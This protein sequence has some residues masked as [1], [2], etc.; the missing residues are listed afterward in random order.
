MYNLYSTP[1]TLEVQNWR[2]IT[3]GDTRTKKLNI[4]DLENMETLNVYTVYI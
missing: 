3:F 1:T 2:E 4:T